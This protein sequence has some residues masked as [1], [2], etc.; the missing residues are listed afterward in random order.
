MASCPISC[1]SVIR[2][3][4]PRFNGG[5]KGG[6]ED[7]LIPVFLRTPFPRPPLT[8]CPYNAWAGRAGRRGGAYYSILIPRSLTK[9]FPS[10]TPPPL[11]SYPTPFFLGAL[12]STFALT[13]SAIY[14]PYNLVE[15]LQLNPDASTLV[16]AVVAGGLGE[17]LPYKPRTF[18]LGYFSSPYPF[19]PL[20]LLSSLLLQL[21]LCR[22]R[23]PSLSWPL[24]T[25]PLS[26]CPLAC[27]PTS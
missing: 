2:L 8:P 18:Y 23:A 16:T 10:F 15:L 9:T 13:A 21:V 5:W 25:L 17:F 12:L 22:E 19:S 24:T 1:S 14:A 27:C 7:T 6:N 20:S 4:F 11:N 3:I 26:A